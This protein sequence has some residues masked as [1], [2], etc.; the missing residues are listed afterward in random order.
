[1]PTYVVG[2]SA[3]VG[4]LFRRER[5][6]LEVLNTPLVHAL[7]GRCLF[8]L[9]GDDH[10]RA[11]G[12]LREPLARRAVGSYSSRLVAVADRHVTRWARSASFDLYQAARD[13]TMAMSA[14]VLLGIDEHDDDGPTLLAA[15]DQFAA[16]TH[17]PRGPLRWC[18]ARYRVGVRSR[19]ELRELIERRARGARAEGDNVLSRL[20]LS[21][22][23]AEPAAGDV[24]DHMLALL[25]AARETTASLI[26]WSLVEL[27]QH[28][29]LRSQMGAESRRAD[30]SP[31]LLAEE[32]ALPVT[33]AV[34][35]ETGRV[36][37]PN[38][39]STRRAVRPFELL[40]FRVKAGQRVS[41]SP[42]ANHFDP[43]EFPAPQMFRPERFVDGLGAMRLW[44]FGG[45]V[46]ACPGRHL[47][48]LMAVTLLTRLQPHGR[49]D[50]LAGT[51][52]RVRYLPTKAPL[53]PVP[54]TLTVTGAG[55]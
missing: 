8:N 2:T 20:V 24:G 10:A 13:L 47:A 43:C 5:G 41:Y 14:G 11:R 16:A 4:E 6:A 42:S 44:T 50:L 31:R 34:V 40:G 35:T 12:L 1:M 7:F 21:W 28:P 26:T 37:S 38:M 27:A 48:T 25:I 3:G 46:H 49:L 18:S 36:H 54:A 33:R 23:A 9:V 19:S 53:D 51:P 22:P 30:A 15:F 55:Q 17:A 32:R 45:G 39:I 29:E 52:T